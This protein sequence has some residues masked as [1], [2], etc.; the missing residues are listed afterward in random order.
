VNA[1]QA[2]AH[3]KPE[4][5]AHFGQ[6][7]CLH[8]VSY[9]RL[10]RDKTAGAGPFRADTRALGD[11]YFT[12]PANLVA[13]MLGAGLALGGAGGSSNKSA[14]RSVSPSF[15]PHI[16][17]LVPVSDSVPTAR[18]TE[19]LQAALTQHCKRSCIMIH[20][21]VV[22]KAVGLGGSDG[23]P[24]TGDAPK[25]E[26]ASPRARTRSTSRGKQQQ[27]QLVEEHLEAGSMT[28]INWLEAQ[29]E[30]HKVRRCERLGVSRM[31]TSRRREGEGK[32]EAEGGGKGEAEG[33]GK[34]ECED[35]AESEGKGK[36]EGIG[37]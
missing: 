3:N 2:V 18:F 4:V 1:I 14:I 32:S 36:G 20:P 19:M 5:M 26:A 16:I 25:G 27:Q 29:E 23:G 11:H 22:A 24:T 12:R 30:A 17:A 15:T 34:T 31:G 37:E 35:E 9:F 7:S 8:T 21:G 33:E 6:V 28:I 13:G 10:N